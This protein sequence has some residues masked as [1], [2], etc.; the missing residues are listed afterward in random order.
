MLSA[1]F[2]GFTPETTKERKRSTTEY[3]IIEKNPMKRRGIELVIYF[4]ACNE[5]APQPNGCK[6]NS[7]Y[8]EFIIH[9]WNSRDKFL[10][11]C[12]IWY[13]NTEN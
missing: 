2:R 13:L 7:E 12:Y 3:V 9:F 10:N 8:T 4:S 1:K 11:P 5:A 6:K